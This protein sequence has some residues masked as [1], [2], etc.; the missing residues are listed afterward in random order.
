MSIREDIIDQY[1]YDEF[2][3]LDGFDDAV[4][5]V[6]QVDEFYRVVYSQ[7]KIINILIKRDEMSEEDAVDYYEFNIHHNYFGEKTP[8]FMENF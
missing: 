2:L 6:A 1:P 7:D 3:F 8:I 4:I 5:G